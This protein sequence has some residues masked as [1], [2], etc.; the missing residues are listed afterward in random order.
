MFPCFAFFFCHVFLRRVL[1]LPP[2]PAHPAPCNQ[3]LTLYT[4]LPGNQAYLDLS[5]CVER[6][7]FECSPAHAYALSDLTN[8]AKLLLPPNLFPQVSK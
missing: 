1:F 2:F 7:R 5:V 4:E 3:S 6:P 8:A